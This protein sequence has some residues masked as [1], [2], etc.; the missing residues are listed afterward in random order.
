VTRHRAEDARLDQHPLVR[1]RLRSWVGLLIGSMVWNVLLFL[2]QQPPGVAA[3][4]YSVFRTQPP[5]GRA[6]GVTQFA[7][8]DRVNLARGYLTTRLA[9]GLG[10]RT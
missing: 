6:L 1:V 9:V 10:G 5:H 2:V 7:S 3:V 8:D 4:P